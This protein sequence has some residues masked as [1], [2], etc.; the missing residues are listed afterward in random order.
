MV[1][2]P[3]LDPRV[4][5]GPG[6]LQM[7]TEEK[8]DEEMTDYS[9]FTAAPIKDSSTV[10]DLFHKTVNSQRFTIV[11]IEKLA[12][13]VSQT[14]GYRAFALKKREMS[15]FHGSPHETIPKILSNGFNRDFNV[16]QKYGKVCLHFCDFP[17]KIKVFFF[18]FELK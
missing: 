13:K 17:Q 9:T 1:V 4:P 8:K 5:N 15:L 16:R 10:R 6:N 18:T 2:P 14:N 12:P 11:S 3:H 7:K